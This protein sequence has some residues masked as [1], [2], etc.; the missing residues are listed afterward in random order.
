MA[1]VSGEYEVKTTKK[2]VVWPAPDANGDGEKVWESSR[3]AQGREVGRYTV[4]DKYGQEVRK[5]HAPE[6]FA[7]RPGYD[8]TDN[9]VKVDDRGEVERDRNGE[10][11]SIRPGEA[12]VFNADGSVEILTDE[13]AQYVFAEAHN[14]SVSV[15][16]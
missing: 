12:L 1:L 14:A 16:E 10:A 3:D 6:G 11:I 7:N 15:V 4:K 8:H 13:Y 2:V 5:Y 9:Y